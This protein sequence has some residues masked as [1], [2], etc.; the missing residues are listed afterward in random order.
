MVILIFFWT[1]GKYLITK[2]EGFRRG[3][4]TVCGV[5]VVFVCYALFPS[6]SESSHRVDIGQSGLT[7]SNSVSVIWKKTL[8]QE[9]T[10]DTLFRNCDC[11]WC[12]M[13]L[14]VQGEF[15]S[16]RPKDFL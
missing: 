14:R 1:Y 6:V 8:M 9:G 15:N 2:P 13:F 3:N 12:E 4:I 16:L 10:M 5:T 11:S 7:A